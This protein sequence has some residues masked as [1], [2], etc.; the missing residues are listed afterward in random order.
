MKTKREINIFE[1]LSNI[2][3]RQVNGKTMSNNIQQNF[4]EIR[5]KI[6]NTFGQNYFI[7]KYLKFCMDNFTLAAKYHNKK[8]KVIKLKFH[9]TIGRCWKGLEKNLGV[10]LLYKFLF[11][12]FYKNV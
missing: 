11:F 8:K 6:S 3:V 5:W 10:R 7:K 2:R 9:F 4:L 12:Y 1:I